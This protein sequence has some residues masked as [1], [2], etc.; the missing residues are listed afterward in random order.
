M[1][2]PVSPLLEARMRILE[3]LNGEAK[4]LPEV[5][6]ELNM[7]MVDLA[8]LMQGMW[9]EGIVARTGESQGPHWMQVPG[10]TI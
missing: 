3:A 5:R 7:R 10:K 8:L 6:R 2:P 1:K 9:H 4:T